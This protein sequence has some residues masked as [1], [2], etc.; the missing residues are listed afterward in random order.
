MTGA[1]DDA[2]NAATRQLV[3]LGA[4]HAHLHVLQTLAAH[5][6][7]GVQVTLV[8]P[9]SVQIYS[10]M[11]PGLVAGHYALEDCLI[12]L[13][14][15]LHRSGIHWLRHVVRAL[16]ADAQTLELDDGSS[17]HFDWLSVNTGGV[18]DRAQLEHTLPGA[19]TFG[20]FVR[21]LDAF[22]A[23][24]PRVVA[25]GQT[26]S[27]RVVVI[28]AGAAGIELALAVRQRLPNAAITLLCGTAP[29][30]ANYP[31][32]V[33][34][35]LQSILKSR[36]I[37]VLHDTAVSLHT[38][39]VRLGSGAT[40]ACNVPL[41]ATGV[42]A[43]AWLRTSGMARDGAGFIAVDAC[44]RSTS[45]P[46]V[47]A[48]GDVSTR[49]DRPVQQPIARSGVYA[50]RAGPALAHNLGAAA[51]GKPLRTHQPPAHCLNL[52][53]CGDRYAIASWGRFSTQGRWVWW[54]K[55]WIDQRF[56]RQYEK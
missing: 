5:P 49:V 21:P 18:Q 47:F 52:L 35:H 8:A 38:D 10:G 31:R 1:G 17:L 24:W 9:H 44:Q 12:A 48:A 28:G 19:R 45:H 20:L 51:T 15:L 3:L 30:G 54:L 33:Q 46:L 11:V 43:P 32:R 42:Q 13:E 40:L 39:A 25:L 55:S 27:L 7:P 37:T 14:P 26:Q 53:S 2:M 23:L 50:V 4:G 56:V 6:L 29:P 41:I 22:A 34:E 36:H 16:N